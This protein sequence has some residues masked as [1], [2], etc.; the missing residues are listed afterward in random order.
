VEIVCPP[1]QPIYHL[2]P[3]SEL[4]SGLTQIS[5]SPARLGEDGFVHC[6]GTPA[7][8][9]AVAADYFADLEQTLYVLVVDPAK[10]SATLRFEEP[11]PIPGGGVDHLNQAVTFP[12][13]YGPIDREAIVEAAAL[14]KSD[15]G[16]DWPERMSSLDET[17]A[18]M[19]RA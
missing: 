4:R 15:G 17:L 1:P 6:A 9:L 8:T 13:I 16:Y 10:L 7:V 19:D 3:A 2:A 18:G 5:Y 11:E 14:V 12:H